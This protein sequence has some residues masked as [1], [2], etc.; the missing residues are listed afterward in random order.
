M[1][2]RTGVPSLIDVAKRL[3]D[4]IFTFQPVIA[5]AYPSNATLQAALTTAM[6]ACQELHLQLEQVREYGD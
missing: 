6:I 4:L 1:T 5:R 2:R 3:C